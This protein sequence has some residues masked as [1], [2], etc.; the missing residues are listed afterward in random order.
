MQ[1]NLLRAVAGG[2]VNE[3]QQLLTK[4]ICVVE[5]R[6]KKEPIWVDQL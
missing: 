2:A 6:V 1:E 5:R 3:G 4:S